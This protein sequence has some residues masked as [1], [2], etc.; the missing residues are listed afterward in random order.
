[1]PRFPQ[2]A[3]HGETTTIVTGPSQATGYTIVAGTEFRTE[4]GRSRSSSPKYP[5]VNNLA[6]RAHPAMGHGCDALPERGVFDKSHNHQ[7]RSAPRLVIEAT[8]TV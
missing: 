7:A 6:I 1:M 3:D 4:P 8:F 5:S 2:L